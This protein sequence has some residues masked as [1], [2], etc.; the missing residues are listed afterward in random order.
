MWQRR[1]RPD[2]TIHSRHSVE[3][4][5]SVSGLLLDHALSGSWLS[6]ASG[7]RGAITGA[8]SPI[9]QQSRIPPVTRR[10]FHRSGYTPYDSAGGPAA[11]PG[12]PHHPLPSPGSAPG[13]RHCAARRHGPQK[14]LCGVGMHERVHAVEV[15][16]ETTQMGLAARCSL[17]TLPQPAFRGTARE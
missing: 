12:E 9:V 13:A 4:N 10:S 11:G 2:P 5:P 15:R 17:E 7:G 3:M 6:I 8:N 1:G 14:K 16:R